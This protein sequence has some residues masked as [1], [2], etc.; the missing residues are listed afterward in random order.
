[1]EEIVA[2]ALYLVSTPIGN[3]ADISHRAIHILTNVSLIAA[4]DT[5][6]SRVLLTKYNIKRPILSY[7]SHN[8]L[9]KVDSL[10]SRLKSGQSIALISDAGTPG[11]SDPAYSL[12]TRAIEEKVRIIPIPGASA[13]LAALVTS[14][15]PTNRFV[16]EGFLP[17]KK[18]RRT[19]IAELKAEKRTIVIYESPHRILKTTRELY[20]SWGDRKCV[21]ARELTKK[22][23]EITRGFLSEIITHL[24]TGPVKGEYVII[25]EGKN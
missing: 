7:H 9:K 20:Q 21:I 16:F 8:Q 24:E 6:I 15:L 22:F 1:M 25:I 12:V 13:L 3:L 5:R 10:L 2:G 19:K 18:G 17:Q 4:E 11:I 14:G 23:E